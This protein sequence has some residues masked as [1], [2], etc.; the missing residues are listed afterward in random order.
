MLAI[1]ASVTHDGKQYKVHSLPSSRDAAVVEA[2]CAHKQR[3]EEHSSAERAM[4]HLALDWSAT[5]KV[6][7]T[8]AAAAAAWAARQ[9]IA[10]GWSEV[11]RQL[12]ACADQANRSGGGREEEP[13]G[14]SLL[15]AAA[16][17]DLPGALLALASVC[18]A[19]I[20]WADMTGR[21]LAHIAA[22]QGSAAALEALLKGGY[23][24]PSDTTCGGDSLLHVAA[25]GQMPG[26]L[27]AMRLLL[28]LS[29][30]LTMAHG[31]G[32]Y[33][34]LH[35]AAEGG[36]P[37]SVSL[38]LHAGPQAATWAAEQDG[39]IPLHVASLRGNAEVVELLLAAAPET[40]IW[41][42]H[43]SGANSLHLAAQRGHVATMEALLR[44]A[45]KAALSQDMNGW[46]PALSFKSRYNDTALSLALLHNGGWDRLAT[47]RALLDATP[48]EE[49]LKAMRV[50]SI[51]LPG[52]LVGRIMSL[53]LAI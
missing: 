24:A 26:H 17:L 29:P 43:D 2:A 50:L 33:L 22:Q 47:A 27:A 19:A 46:L 40:A 52:F 32:G 6:S 9:L 36:S 13:P 30:E 25:G 37:E 20:A 5:T 11:T 39:R 45:P 35:L 49:G 41:P 10:V 23:A 28:R 1:T 42:D 53:C 48:L 44:V 15:V 14:L 8:P 16:S 34:A 38:L 7:L 31:D 21:Q 51:P 4:Q 18:P 3:L 12:Q